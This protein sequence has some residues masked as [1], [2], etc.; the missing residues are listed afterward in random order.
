MSFNIFSAIK[1]F[2]FKAFE[3]ETADGRTKERHR[4]A[5]LTVLASGVSRGI[6]L[7][8]IVISLRIALPYLGEERFGVMSTITS[9]SML[10]TF[11]DLGIGNGLVSQIARLRGADDDSGLA[12]L[13][14]NALLI[15]S[16]I[17]I[18]V[19]CV[20]LLLFWF[21]PLAWAFKG[22]Q[23][24]TLAEAHFTLMVFSILFGLSIPFGAVQRIFAGMQE[25]YVAQIVS[26]AV[27]LFGLVVLY[28]LPS[29]NAGIP[30]FL[31]AT[32]GMQV[33]SGAVL[34]IPLFAKKLIRIFVRPLFKYPEVKVL[35]KTSGLFFILQ[36]SGVIGF[37]SDNLIV[38]ATLGSVA[39]TQFTLVQRIFMLITIP[40]V[41]INAPLWAGYADAASKGDLDFIKSTFKRSM[42]MT[43][44][45][46]FCG[47]VIII[48]AQQFFADIFSK[49]T[50]VLDVRLVL[51]FAIWIVIESTGNAFAMYLNGMHVVKPQ[52]PAIIAFI[53][54]SIPL[55]LFF[56]STVGLEGL[57]LATILAYTVTH[58]VPYLWYFRTRLFL[59]E[60]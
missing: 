46:A 44:V 48:L 2:R 27:S 20:L 40:L 19:T 16:L 4:R 38:S 12:R 11:L 36:I 24:A 28:F 52:V 60:T 18:V 59:P 43:P 13:I 32:Y 23:P 39:V 8:S 9:I 26:G 6:S 58:I 56:I 30:A 55:K 14:S 7:L 42:V 31:A 22:I 1:F 5:L 47:G 45:L 29:L 35:L 57:V 50:V 10:L 15:L 49:N 41:L 37:G 3:T 51:F 21:L 34:L 54:V 17:G 33:L 53:L 25:G